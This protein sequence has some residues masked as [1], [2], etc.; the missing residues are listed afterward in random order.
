RPDSKCRR[1]QGTKGLWLEDSTSIHIE[2][3]SEP[4]QWE[5]FEDYMREF[6]HPLWKQYLVD[7]IRGGHNGVDYLVARA[8]IESVKAKQSPPVDVYD[9]AAW[10]AITA[11]SEQSVALGGQTVAFPDFTNGKWINRRA[12]AP[13]KY[14]LDSINAEPETASPREAAKA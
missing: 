9:M 5:A 3:R 7:G 10:M 13:G 6:D 11:L 14:S 12:A 8:F 2:G 1:V 4:H